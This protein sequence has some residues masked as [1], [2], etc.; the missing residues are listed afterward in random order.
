MHPIQRPG[1]GETALSRALGCK[2]PSDS[3]ENLAEWAGGVAGPCPCPR[4]PREKGGGRPAPQSLVL[5]DDPGQQKPGSQSRAFGDKEISCQ[6]ISQWEEVVN[7]VRLEEKVRWKL[8]TRHHLGLLGTGERSQHLPE[9]S[10][11][12]P[13]PQ[14]TCEHS[15]GEGREGS[16]KMD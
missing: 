12:W 10:L 1:R 16:M 3:E 13:Q 11:K 5:R 6:E 7:V 4:I 15:G 14:E 9:Y 2:E 8:S